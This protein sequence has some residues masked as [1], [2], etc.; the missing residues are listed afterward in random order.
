MPAELHQD[1]GVYKCKQWVFLCHY[2]VWLQRTKYDGTKKL[3]PQTG[4][5]LQMVQSWD[6]RRTAGMH[7]LGTEQKKRF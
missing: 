2:V 1:D 4:R 3:S 7:A 6:W 5:V